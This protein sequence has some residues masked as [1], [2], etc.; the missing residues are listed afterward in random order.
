MSDSAAEF[1]VGDV[2]EYEVPAFYREKAY[3]ASIRLASGLRLALHAYH[4]FGVVQHVAPI[5]SGVYSYITCIRLGADLR[6]C[7]PSYEL[8]KVTM[9]DVRGDSHA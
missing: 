9:P 6:D 1:Q 3:N 8:K 7:L 2:V 4:T 5:E